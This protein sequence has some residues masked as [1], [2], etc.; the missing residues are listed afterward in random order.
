M[1]ILTDAQLHCLAHGASLYLIPGGIAELF[2]S[3]PKVEKICTFHKG[4]VRLA[5]KAGVPI[6]PIYL[7]GHTRLF[8]QT[9][10]DSGFAIVLSRLIKSVFT[11]Y[12]GQ[13]CSIVSS[14][15]LIR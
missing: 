7:F 6:V 2:F 10:T 12:Y 15:L 8:H 9:A 13:V 4:F 11:L 5:I 1:A 14:T 3:D